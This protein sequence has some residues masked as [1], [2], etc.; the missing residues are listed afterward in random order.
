MPLTPEEQAELDQLETE[1][2]PKLTPEEY[3]E[4]A[5]LEAELEPEPKEVIPEKVDAFEA[6]K[7]EAA[8]VGP[9]EAVT[10]SVIDNFT[11]GNYPDA[12]A[13]LADIFE[14]M[15]IEKQK[16]LYRIR[17]EA[18]K[19]NYPD[20]YAVAGIVAEATKWAGAFGA[21][22]LALGT[23]KTAFKSGQG[24][25]R[26]SKVLPKKAVEVY[27]KVPKEVTEGV[28]AAVDAMASGSPRSGY[29]AL[30]QAAR[31]GG[32][33]V[34]AVK[35]VKK[36]ATDAVT[37][38]IKTPAKIKTPPTKTPYKVKYKTKPTEAIKKARDKP[39][40]TKTKALDKLQQGI[41]K[42]VLETI[43]ASPKELTKPQL[44]AKVA[45]VYNKEILAKGK[46]LES[47]K[48]SAKNISKLIDRLEKGKK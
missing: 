14:S 31:L 1:L 37:K 27:K 38:A 39:P 9:L 25:Y 23:A 35:A 24:A 22:K 17:Q 7:K 28:L 36:P 40:S 15:P 11:A 44:R 45:K 47:A 43:K 48:E 33:A 29:Q 46:P 21:G 20:T 26:A 6:E 12:M 2:T 16:E 34:K 4:L 10:S 5:Q 3:A 19:K 41:E 13:S 42:K 30:K 18:A 8:D 32:K